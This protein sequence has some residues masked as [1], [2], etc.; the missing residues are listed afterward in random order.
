MDNL[1]KLKESLRY[2]KQYIKALQISP[3]FRLFEGE[4]I[5]RRNM[6]EKIIKGIEYY[7]KKSKRDVQWLRRC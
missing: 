6:I 1:E 2:H 4:I 5:K 3:C 7:E